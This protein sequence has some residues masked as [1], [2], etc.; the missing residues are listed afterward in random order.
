MYQKQQ[1]SSH[2]ALH[3][4]IAPTA[5]AA[6]GP[7][8]GLRPA[9]VGAMA[10]AGAAATVGLAATAS[11][12]ATVGA[13]ATPWVR[14]RPSD[15]GCGG[16]RGGGGDRT[17]GEAVT[18]GRGLLVATAAPPAAAPAVVSGCAASKP[19]SDGDGQ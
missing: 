1:L 6:A 7:T 4:I 13:A 16:D 5:F 11:A 10:I 15:R 9:P 14:R 17:A 18:M 8:G 2:K 3:R 12:A 19:K